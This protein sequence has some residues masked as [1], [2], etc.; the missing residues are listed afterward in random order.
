MRTD[1]DAE[2]HREISALLVPNDLDGIEITKLNTVVRKA[3]GTN[4]V[5]FDNTGV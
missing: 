3:T 5:F 1:P 2:K 4:Q